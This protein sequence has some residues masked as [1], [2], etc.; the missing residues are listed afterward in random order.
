MLVEPS[1]T[2]HPTAVGLDVPDL[3]MPDHTASRQPSWED[4]GTADGGW[5]GEVVRESTGRWQ[6]E[7]DDGSDGGPKAVG[8][9]ASVD[10]LR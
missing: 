10:P 4:P 3:K 9:A 7:S 2:Q 8:P 1:S 6:S 5:L